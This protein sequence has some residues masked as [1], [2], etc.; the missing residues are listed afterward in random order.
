MTSSLE[1]VYVCDM[2]IAKVKKAAEATVTSV[3]KGPGTFPY[4]APEMFKS[5]RRGPAVDIYSLGCLFIELFGRKRVWPDLDATAIMVKVVGS[6]DTPPEMPDTSHLCHPF[7]GFCSKLCQIE[8]SKRPNIQ[9][10]LRMVKDLR[11]E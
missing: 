3:N 7:G 5:S 11:P 8:P 6:Y 10:V 2:G 1:K 9:E 4:M